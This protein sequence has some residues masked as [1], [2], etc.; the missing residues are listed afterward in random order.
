[1]PGP[2]PPYQALV[3]MLIANSV[4]DGGELVN[5]ERNTSAHSA[6][7]TAHAANGYEGNRASVTRVRK[8]DCM[9]AGDPPLV[10]GGLQYDMTQGD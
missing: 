6:T 10:K 8:V 5:L 4:F 7:A 3:A 9:G 1:M 2:R